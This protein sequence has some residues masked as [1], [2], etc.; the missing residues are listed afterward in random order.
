MAVAN[1]KA[2]GGGM[3]AAPQAELDDGLLDVVAR[4]E[5]SKLHFL[6]LPRC[7]RAPTSTTRACHFRGAE[8]EVDADRPFDIYADGDPVGTVPATIT[9]P[10]RCLR[11]IVPR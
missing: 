7:S 5:V 11:V 8:I 9:V 10:P 1:S 2:Y 4:G 6:A 3:F